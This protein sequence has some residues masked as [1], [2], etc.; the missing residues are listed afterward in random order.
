L[1]TPLEV[2]KIKGLFGFGVSLAPSRKIPLFSSLFDWA[3]R[4]VPHQLAR[5]RRLKKRMR[6]GQ[7][8][9]NLAPS[10]DEGCL[11]GIPFT[12]PFGTRKIP[13]SFPA[14]SN[15]DPLAGRVQTEG[16]GAHSQM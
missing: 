9:R 1:A 11:I 13:Q 7:S 2:A 15:C 14:P 3:S 4:F 10:G 12:P 16:C 8:A 6:E 5:S